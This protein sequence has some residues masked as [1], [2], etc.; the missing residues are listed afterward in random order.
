M[1]S[2]WENVSAFAFSIEDKTQAESTGGLKK[3]ALV[4]EFVKDDVS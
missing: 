4:R 3:S 1:A 2:R